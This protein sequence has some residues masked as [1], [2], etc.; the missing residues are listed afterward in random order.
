[1]RGVGE[2]TQEKRD[3]RPL[4]RHLGGSCEL[5]A[6]RLMRGAS[7]APSSSAIGGAQPGC[8]GLHHARSTCITRASPASRCITC[9]RPAS[10]ASTLHHLHQPCITCINPA[11]RAK[12][13]INPASAA[14]GLHHAHQG[15]RKTQ[16]PSTKHASNA[17]PPLRPL[18]AAPPKRAAG[19]PSQQR[20]RPQRAR[21]R[22]RPD[23]DD[24]QRARARADSPRAAWTAPLRHRTARDVRRAPARGR[25][26]PPVRGGARMER[27][28]EL[29]AECGEKTIR[30]EEGKSSPARLRRREPPATH[31]HITRAS[32]L[33]GRH[34]RRDPRRRESH[35][36]EWAQREDATR[37]TRTMTDDEGTRPYFTATCVR[38]KR[39]PLLAGRLLAHE[40]AASFVR[41]TPTRRPPARAQRRGQRRRRCGEL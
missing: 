10:P 39:P 26:P 4:P 12:G 35:G 36:A 29:P 2:A 38:C 6:S 22:A 24:P 37:D 16:A 8:Q 13:C 21:A 34:R 40:P 28:L 41:A 3:N 7:M 27:G 31:A 1:M 18:P 14:H 32:A 9:I 33:R 25:A 30:E 19:V 15:T 11:S 23:A 5:R 17:K 20:A